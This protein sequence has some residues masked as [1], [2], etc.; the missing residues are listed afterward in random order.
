MKIVFASCSNVQHFSSQP[1]WRRINDLAP[2]VLLLLGDQIYMDFGAK[3]MGG[4]LYAPA[5]MSLPDF[6]KRMYSRYAQQWGVAEFQSLL[7][8]RPDMRIGAIW[9][10]HDFAWN[11]ACGGRPGNAD[12]DKKHK[13]SDRHKWIV[14]SL[15]KQYLNTVSSRAQAYPTPPF[16][17]ENPPDG[18]IPDEDG[19]QQFFD[20]EGGAV[21]VI[22]LDN[23]YHR[24][25]PSAPDPVIMDEAQ[26]KWLE[27]LIAGNQELTL[28]CS[29]STLADAESWSNY[30]RSYK[31][32]LD[33][34][35]NKKVLFLSG[36]IH[37]N[38]FVVHDNPGNGAGQQYPLF[39]AISSGL[40]VKGYKPIKWLGAQENFGL[41]EI[42]PDRLRIDL[43]H[44]GKL[45][46]S[47]KLDRR[48]WH[49][50][51]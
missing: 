48:A 36:D 51:A 39:E 7:R 35:R 17:L 49:D 10:D 26:Q 45:D 3:F 42:T 18:G 20:V 29:G 19:I 14:K 8:N 43:Y 33:V 27:G 25:C 46:E 2:D 24:D 16:D 32:L 28:L 5:T 50:I 38:K 6:S 1:G 30:P 31:Q 23:R 34:V 22:L 41:I 21:R 44:N 9:D 13:V 40:A 37:V 11:N 12:K 4:D 47:H 15:F